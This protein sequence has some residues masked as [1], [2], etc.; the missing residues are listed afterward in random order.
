M[1][2][3]VNLPIDLTL[4][5]IS[6]LSCTSTLFLA[7]A[8]FGAPLQ[9]EANHDYLFSVKNPVRL[10]RAARRKI[11]FSSLNDLF[12]FRSTWP[13]QIRD[14]RRFNWNEVRFGHLRTLWIEKETRSQNRKTSIHQSVQ[15]RPE[16]NFASVTISDQDLPGA[17]V[18]YSYSDT[19]QGKTF[20]T[21]LPLI[22]Q[23]VVGNWTQLLNHQPFILQLTDE[24]QAKFNEFMNERLELLL[25]QRLFE[26]FRPK[27]L[28]RKL[29]MKSLSFKTFASGPNISASEYWKKQLPKNVKR[30][31]KAATYLFGDQHGLVST[32][33]T[34]TIEYDHQITELPSEEMDWTIDKSRYRLIEAFTSVS[35]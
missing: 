4:N 16:N 32:Y 29:W 28:K 26:E 6:R 8:L 13:A 20:Q 18:L 24:S 34:Y 21:Q 10:D 14:G 5:V 23:F 19:I 1:H 27:L 25:N 35:F 3:C 11:E 22:A 2:H 31:L 7:I 9:S 30:D 15:K 17:T 12:E 33:P